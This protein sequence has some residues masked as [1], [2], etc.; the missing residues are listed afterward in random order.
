M[1]VA[2]GEEPPDEAIRLTGGSDLDL[3]GGTGTLPSVPNQKIIASGAARSA[4]RPRERNHH[5]SVRHL[6]RTPF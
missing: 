3:D 6:D 2:Q 5:D 1:P 4:R